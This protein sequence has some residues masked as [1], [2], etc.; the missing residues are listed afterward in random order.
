MGD[1]TAP[2]GLYAWLCHA[3]LGFIFCDP[4]EIRVWVRVRFMVS[5]RVRVKDSYRVST[6]LILAG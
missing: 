2:S 1:T 3:F 4:T 6:I 5:V